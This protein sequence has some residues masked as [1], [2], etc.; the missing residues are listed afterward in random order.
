MVETP[1]AALAVLVAVVLV[2]VE[3]EWQEITQPQTQVAVPEAVVVIKGLV[4]V[5]AL[6]LSL[7]VIRVHRL[8]L[9]E[10]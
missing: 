5:E 7:F 1:L 3:V 2:L 10:Q 9:V 8:G 4:L 6:G